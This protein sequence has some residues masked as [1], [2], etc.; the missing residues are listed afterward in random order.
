MTKITNQM[1][2]NRQKKKRLVMSAFVMTLF[3][4]L[5]TQFAQAQSTSVYMKDGNKTIQRGDGAISFYD[6][7]GPSGAAT[8]Y[9]ETWYNHKESF[10]YVFKPA[11]SGDKIKVTFNTFQCWAEPASGSTGVDIGD[12]ALR[13]NDD[14]LYIYEGNGAVDANLIA[15][16]TGNTRQSFSVMTDGAIT[17]K[18]VSNERYREEGWYATVELVQGNM[19]SQAPLIQ[20]STCSDQVEI[21]PT[22]NNARIIYSIGDNDPEPADPL[23]PPSYEYTGPISFPEGTIPS[24]GFK[25]NA[26]SQLATGGTWSSVT[27]AV[28]QES[29]RVP[30]P[31]EDD[32]HAHTTIT[33]VDGTNTIVMTPA[34]RPDGLNDT[35]VVRYTM[36]T[37]GSEPADPTIN[38]STLYEGPITASVNG[39]IFKA[40][41]FAVSCSNQCSATSV[42][43]VVEGIYAPTP[44][45]DLD[46]MT[47][48]A[49]DEAGTTF[50]ILYTLDGTIPASG[51]PDDPDNEPI[52]NY[53][54]TQVT[55]TGLTPGQTVRAMAYR[56]NGDEF[57]TANSLYI[58]SAIVSAIYIPASGSGVYNDEI[59][60]LDDREDHNWSYYSDETSPIKSLNPADIKITYYGNSVQ[61][62]TTMT[63]ASENGATPT[64]FSA[65][66]SGVQVNV[67]EKG[68]QFIYLKTLEKDETSGNY[69]YTMIANPFQ[70]RPTFSSG[71]STRTFVLTLSNADR[72]N[73]WSGYGT[74]PATVTVS[75]SDGSASQEYSGPTSSYS[76]PV[77]YNITKPVGTTV[78]VTFN[79][80]N[81]S[82]PTD[83]QVA[84]A[85]QDG[86]NILSTT[87]GTSNTS[88]LTTFTITAGS[89]SD[90]NKYRGFYAWRIKSLSDGLTINGK[91]VNGIVYADEEIAF[92]T[93]NA[94]GNEVE[95]EALWA[96]AYVNSSTYVSNGTGNYANYKNAYERNFKV[97]SSLT[98]YNYPVTF[99]SIYPDGS[100]GSGG[101]GTVAT[102]T[103]STNY[104]SSNMVKLENMKI[105]TTGYLDAHGYD[106]VFGRG[107]TPTTTTNN[108]VCFANLY[109]YYNPSESTTI[110]CL[111]RVESGAFTNV[112]G[113]YYSSGR[114][115]TSTGNS[116]RFVYGSDYDRANH[117]QSTLR[118]GDFL[119]CYGINFSDNHLDKV[120]VLSGTYNTRFY[121][122]YYYSFN[123]N[124]AKGR[125]EVLVEGGLFNCDFAGGINGGS[126]TVDS[127]SIRVKNGDFN[128]AIYCSGEYSTA[129]GNRRLVITG[130]SVKGWIA[131]GCNGLTTSTATSGGDL[132]GDTYVYIGGNTIVNSNGNTSVIGNSTSLGG[133]VY[134]A[135]SGKPEV[136]EMGQVNNSTIVIA[137]NAAIERNVFGGGNYGYVNYNSGQSD[138]YVLGGTVT[139]SVFG[140]SNLRN[141]YK[142]NIYMKNGTISQN[143]YGG[144]NEQGTIYNLASISV[145]GGTVNNIYGGGYGSNT[146]MSTNGT[147]ITVTDGT[148][149]N[150][151]Y[152]GG[153]QGIVQGA[154]T[155]SF[156]G[157]SVNDIY[158]A[159]KGTEVET[160]GSAASA[161]VARGTIVNVK[162]GVVDGSVYGGGEFGTVAFASG[163][164]TS[165]Y[166]STVSIS[167]G[168]VKGDVFGGGKEGTTQGKTTVNVS[169]TWDGTVIRGNVFAGAYGEHDK[170]YVAGLKTLNIS[171]GRIYGS[172]YGGS[173]N[174]NDG[175]TLNATGGTD[176][177]SITN[178]SGGRID[179]HVYAAGYYGST[180]GSVYA[181]IGLNAINEAPNSPH[182]A[183]GATPYAFDKTS[184]LIAGSVW[185]GG[186]WGVFTGT[187]GAPTITGNSN[188]YINGEGYS[189]DGNDQSATNYMNIKTSILGCGT[190]CD[191]GAGERTLI[192][193]HYGADVSNS[194]AD[195]AENPFSSASRQVNTIQRF[196]NVIFDDAKLGFVG[197]G[198]INSLNATEKYALYEIDKNVYLANGSTMVMNVPS[199]QIYSFHSVTCP[200]AYAT[201]PSFTAVNYDGLGETGGET[202]NKI[203]V[204]GGSYIEIKYVPETTSGGGSGGDEPSGEDEILT[205]DFE[206]GSL[207]DWTTIDADNDGN[208]WIIA[209][210]AAYNIGDAHSG[211]YCASSWSWNNET[212]YPDNYMISP[213]V[214]GATSIQYYV[215]TNTAYPDHYAVMASTTGNAASD[216][217]TVFEETAP[218][219]KNAVIGGER[220]SMTRPGTRALSPWT[221]RN[222]NLPAGTKYVAF[223]H[224]NS[225]DMNYLLIDDITITIP[226]EEPEDPQDPEEPTFTYTAAYGELEGF[227]HMMAGNPDEDA[228]C[229]YARP[230][231]ST[232][233]GNI[234][235]ADS[236]AFF[237]LSDGGWV[238]Y[239]DDENEYD[240]GGGMANPTPGVQLRYEN[241]YPNMRNN[242]EFYRIWRK[243]GDHYTI[244]AVANVHANGIAG[245]YNT[246]EVEVELPSWRAAGSYFRFDRTNNVG[247]N[248]TLIDYGSDV[249]TFN[250][251]NYSNPLGASTWMYWQDNATTPQVTGVGA[252]NATVAAAIGQNGILSNPNLNFG[253]VIE[254]GKTMKSTDVNYI[255]NSE[256]DV[257]LASVE[258]PFNCDDNTHKPTIKLVLTFSDELSANASLDPVLIKLVQC[259]AQGNIKD[260]VTIKLIINT[261][262][263][264][265]SGFKTQ[266]YAR[267]DG[268]ANRRET[269]TVS[270]VLPT[271]NVAT[272]GENAKFYLQKVDFIQNGGVVLDPDN[273]GSSVTCAEARE[274]ASS[275]GTMLNIDRFAMTI[276]ALPNPDNSDD[277]RNITGAQD[278]VQQPNS[279]YGT[280]VWGG[281]NN[282]GPRLGDGKGRNPLSLGIT[283]YFDSNAEAPGKSKMGDMVFTILVEN[284]EGGT[285]TNHTSTFTITVEVY[286]LGPGDNFYVDGINGQDLD[287]EDRAKF[288]DKAARTVNFIF[289]RLG[290]M[291][292]DNIIV[293]N[294]LPISR[295]ITWDGSKFQNN[296]KIYRYS[297]GHKLT[298]G[299][300][301]TESN[302]N[303]PYLGPLVDVTNTL[304]MKGIIM[305]GMYAESTA[306]IDGVHNPKLYPTGDAGDCTFDGIAE[307]PLITISNGARVN[308]TDSKL[309]NNYNSKTEKANAGGAIHVTY[310]GIL[311]MNSANRITGNYN[312]NGGGV[313]VDG[314][315]IVS[316]YAYVF[317]NYTE[318]V[319]GSKVDPEQNNVMLEKLTEGS[320]R[321]VQVGTSD[322][323]DAFDQLLKTD[324]EGETKIG[325]TKDDWVHG[326]DGYMPIVYAEPGSLT[327]LNDP[328]NTQTMV[329]HD[330]GKYR[331]ERYVSSE[332]SDSPN[333]LYWLET[334]VTA[335]TS[336]PD[337]FKADSIDTPAELAW[338]ISIV[339]GENGCTP[340][341]NTNFTLTDDIDMS[342]HIWVPIGNETTLYNGTFEGN[343]H[344]VTGLN[345]SITR[346]D[347]GMF[348][349]TNT[350]ANIQ[351]MMVNTEFNTN[352][353]NLGT[354]VG[355]MIGG[356]LSNVEGSG[357]NTSRNTAGNNGGLVG[358]NGGGTIHSAF[359]VTT[360]KGGQNV[361]G[362]VGVNNNDLFNSYS[363]ADMSDGNAMAGLVATNNGR[364]E[365]CYD[366][367]NADVAFASK[368]NGTIRYCYTA[369]P[370][371]GDPTYVSLS[372]DESTLEKY[373]TYGAVKGIKELGYMYGDNKITAAAN[374]T[375]GYV[376]TTH[377]Y[378]DKHTVV[379]DGLLSVLNQWVADGNVQGKPSGLSTWNRPLTQALNGDLPVLAFPMDN[380]LGNVAAEDGKMLRYSAFDR[381]DLRNNNGLDY[382]LGTVYKNK[383]AN[384]YLYDSTA[385]V[386]SGTGSNKLF[387]HEDAALLQAEAASSG[388]AME[389]I[390]ATVGVT[391]DNSCGH[392]DD[393]FGNTL[394]YDWHLLSTPLSDAPLG[395]TYNESVDQNWWEDQDSGQVT[396]VSHSYMPD[397]INAQSEVKWDFYTYY[398]P[399]YH[400]INFKR[401][402]ASHNHYDA[403]HDPIDY[404]NETNLIQGRGYMMAISTDSYMSNDGTLNNGTVSIPLTVSG[405]LPETDLPSKDWGSNLVGN[406]YQAYLDLDKVTSNTGQSEFYI[407]DAD[408]GVYGPYT[409]GAS[410]N[411]AIPSKLIHPHQAFFVVTDKTKNNEG[412]AFTYDMATTDKNAASY[413][414]GEEQPKYPLVNLFAENENGNRDLAVI[415][416]N[417][418]ELNGVRK[419]NNL[420][421]ANFKISAHL[422]RQ[423]Y[424]LVFVPEGT[425]KVPVHF[426]TTEDGTFTLR[427][428][429]MHGTFTSL[430]LVDNLTGTH[431]DMLRNDHYTFNG[432]VDDYAARFYIT[433]NVTDVDELNG[434]G[435]QFAWYD[436]NDW[437]VTGKG[438]IEVIDVTGR[439]LKSMRV[440][441]D[442]TRI[443]L[444]GYAAGVYM[445]RMSG[446]NNVKTQK[447]VVK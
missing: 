425:E 208:T 103:S 108:A 405:E 199:S 7:H 412:F 419:V 366:V 184:I 170:I 241:H 165:T 58:P 18:F 381:D 370:A 29:D 231:Q 325:V 276:A 339:N 175:N 52:G 364:V 417:R 371:E 314:A 24:T 349:R 435:E 158:G 301:S 48:T 237:N 145:S 40:K 118:V 396:G 444:E 387:I 139:G 344:L 282:R 143:I 16:L 333:F 180:K 399:E 92:E 51:N 60:L 258:K 11:V 130:G 320:F 153:E 329:V 164:G 41:T 297:G 328:Y 446:N 437:I 324:D 216:F 338:A 54:A 14:Y 95:F 293:V 214:D 25:V 78:T 438:Q 408:N 152:G 191:A 149:N 221:E 233:T 34:W 361:G 445:L 67:N 32:E 428:Q 227:A 351:N 132:D 187:F 418:P 352:S 243:G 55:L 161:N 93:S 385:N 404:T 120:K 116:I 302:P 201:S 174:A 235:P 290:Y 292:G 207:S 223:R 439:V 44:V 162:G 189:T 274:S 181:F 203:R 392:A 177:T 389:T 12:W 386:V 367:T 353:D 128:G 429:T 146:T 106:F 192:L 341:P 230:K 211:T 312:V 304:N 121:N 196:H 384:I 239:T 198:K 81:Q 47:I 215:A 80:G 403:P 317:D 90:T 330:G 390:K 248:N 397:N 50:E 345:G 2:S 85:Y 379:W 144:S 213:L 115:M 388:K 308:M 209:T 63:N 102:V 141:G 98:T 377:E 212:L 182:S 363:A 220:S 167:G 254:P 173:R 28:F 176:A 340:A 43:Y 4:A 127:I 65:S 224:F 315:M 56:S 38:N 197:Q 155:V 148:I 433:Y 107:V 30:F 252:D 122:G 300:T 360:I 272:S 346:T 226:A 138:I 332:Y 31:D 424:S 309:Q 61:G 415:E 382:L 147:K 169:G 84:I 134:G 105:S 391:F 20:R 245:A 280:L 296:V 53:S 200:N 186:D 409:T 9:W 277:W 410:I 440:S 261:S 375:I 427:W 406:P 140:G 68:N 334:W 393:Y 10:T 284:I 298:T 442:Q 194:G 289:N 83:C 97:V 150:N 348:G 151:I 311:A 374:Q 240:A 159:G 94:K 19:A 401:N 420:R 262:M 27:H 287:D 133:N 23:A 206:D 111:L 358:V 5:F 244:E 413:Y 299:G 218:I 126:S 253:L 265:T 172:I 219:S 294:T 323:N 193:S 82:Y 376:K 142:V 414:R 327:Y 101:T 179:Q 286:R 42:R 402:S 441:G 256:A 398:E 383:E 136:A 75:F 205:Y 313:Y 64:T 285:G 110:N 22:T 1:V 257:W 112:R 236:S 416:F 77:A 46:A 131:G 331:L 421:N 271:F 395:I 316:D 411:T 436:G 368:N 99:S 163:N 154:T 426:K 69:P 432:S 234:L 86:T 430:I 79:P 310:E 87:S 372:G 355:T 217:T 195:N 407:Y 129:V 37:N 378:P 124:R 260:Y 322:S 443:H 35:Y 36:T 273:H 268:S 188:I 117:T 278:A 356:T 249:M 72:Y 70:V 307:A 190:S 96:Q 33:R 422:G 228:T 291:P 74:T 303:E 251:A 183:S 306:P 266:I 17:F 295:V 62:R 168:E 3:M 21:F 365:N 26:M 156:E 318:A 359:A 109:G 238:S 259:D 288:P 281:S 423:G 232:E 394:L 326:Y 275:S 373:G 431:T 157:G 104:V 66:A 225:D 89:S 350:A 39:T 270:V 336:Q 119:L 335:V 185:A 210:P 59:I 267:M 229:A 135:G 88:T 178:I 255:I 8:N 13:L 123:D 171:G 337:G 369:K 357:D 242:S 279:G 114:T 71:G 222:I 15:T 247:D 250:G 113:A 283:M 342:E 343:G 76:T 354:V 204:N 6:S 100:N 380:C 400:W 347:M 45:I 319:S 137:D 321:V 125:R 264:L 434:N 202:D 269:S 73:N 447:I 49:V 57:H 160:P 305:D 246:V 166:N 362:L 91:S 263:N